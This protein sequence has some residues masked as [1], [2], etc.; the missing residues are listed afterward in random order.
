MAGDSKVLVY[1]HRHIATH[2]IIPDGLAIIT[3]SQL[4][5]IL[6]K[7]ESPN[8]SSFPSNSERSSADIL[9]FATDT[10]LQRSTKPISKG[11]L[12]VDIY[13][14]DLLTEAQKPQWAGMPNYE[15]NVAGVSVPW[16]VWLGKLVGSKEFDDLVILSA[17]R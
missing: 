4:D 9:V 5:S 13:E 12:N 8:S 2:P 7:R 1:H 10:A 15:S 6:Q 17:K 14:R 3:A 11:S 16:K